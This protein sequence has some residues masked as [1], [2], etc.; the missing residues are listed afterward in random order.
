[1]EQHALR[2][3]R[4]APRHRAVQALLLAMSRQATHRADR[5]RIVEL[6]RGGKLIL[7][8][9]DILRDLYFFGLDYEAETSAVVAALVGAGDEVVDVGAH[10]GYYTMLMAE[11]V[12]RS[13]RVHAF[14]P[15]PEL[16]DLLEQSIRLNG[17]E[18]RVVRN[19]SAVSDSAAR[20]VPLYVSRHTQN[21]GL[22]SL[23]PHAVP[24]REGFL[25][26]DCT[27]PVDTVR[28]DDY[29][30]EYGVRTCALVKI[31]VECAEAAVLRGMGG[32]LERDPPRAILCET[33]PGSD[34]DQWLCG[35]GF[36]RCGIETPPP[37][38]ALESGEWWLNILYLASHSAAA[39]KARLSAV[40]IR[41]WAY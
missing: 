37:G 21:R 24:L 26:P 20:G 28:L 19:R 30:A 9:S 22:S 17:F 15:N 4:A 35:H 33:Y 32:V 25:S 29:C 10:C 41:Q 27:V 11:R 31:D 3:G 5:C 6:P 1:M 36:E 34:A 23:R 18:D 2:L 7:D 14:E 39:L 8:I 12:G 13:G 38:V 16:I 40:G